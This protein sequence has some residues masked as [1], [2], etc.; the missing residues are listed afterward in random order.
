MTLAQMEKTIREVSKGLAYLR[1]AR[2]ATG[3]DLKYK[4]DTALGYLK[5]AVKRIE[6]N[7][8]QRPT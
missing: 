1:E 6:E 3:P 7:L 2:W 8:I 4:L 5:S